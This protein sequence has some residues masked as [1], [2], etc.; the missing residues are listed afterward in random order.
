MANEMKHYEGWK[1][2][3]VA[4][5][6]ILLTPLQELEWYWILLSWGIAWFVSSLILESYYN[7]KD[8]KRWKKEEAN[9]EIEKLNNILN[10]IITINKNINN[11]FDERFRGLE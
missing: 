3:F 4:T 8:I 10:D 6:I 7:M 5:A 9:T 11:E 1:S 2:V